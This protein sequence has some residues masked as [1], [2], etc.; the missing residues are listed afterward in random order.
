M[1]IAYKNVMNIYKKQK[2]I[3]E[4]LWHFVLLCFFARNINFDSKYMVGVSGV[5]ASV[6]N[7]HL[8]G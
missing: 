3:V 2:N 4:Q 5:I 7:G 1:S 8:V 6:C